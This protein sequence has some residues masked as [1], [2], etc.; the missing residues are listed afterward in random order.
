MWNF[1]IIMGIFLIIDL[2]YLIFWTAVYPFRRN[3][4][5][6]TVSMEEKREQV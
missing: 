3:L 1:F 4:E 2:A 6:Q 5:M